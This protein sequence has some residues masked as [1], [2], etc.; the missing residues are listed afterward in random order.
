MYPSDKR[1]KREK[2]SR[3]DNAVAGTSRIQSFFIT[4]TAD[5]DEICEGNPG[6][7]N[8]DA[9]FGLT[10]QWIRELYFSRLDWVVLDRLQRCTFTLCVGSITSPA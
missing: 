1:K 7:S 4:N 10:Q 6:N 8:G 2:K 9:V 3:L 5:E